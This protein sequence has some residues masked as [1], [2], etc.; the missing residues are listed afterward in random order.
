[1]NL[2]DY[3]LI[4]MDDHPLWT[5]ATMIPDAENPTHTLRY[6]KKRSIDHQTW[7]DVYQWHLRDMVTGSLFWELNYT[8]G[9]YHILFKGS[10]ITVSPS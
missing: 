5:T 2:D 7:E 4:D 8:D 6:A 10:V 3:D 1:M 9:V